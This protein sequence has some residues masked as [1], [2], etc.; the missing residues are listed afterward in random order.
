MNLITPQHLL[1]TY[2]SVNGDIKKFEKEIPYVLIPDAIRKY[3]IPRQYTHFEEDS[4]GD[5]SW[6]KF[7][8]NIRQI[9]KK[10]VDEI[11]GTFTAKPNKCA[12]GGKTH[13]EVFEKTNRY[14]NSDYFYGVKKHLVQ[15]FIFDEFIR[16]IID[17]SRKR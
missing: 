17:T 15:D 4:K 3:S 5:I 10:K 13:V 2:F 14:L 9:T 12:L 7:P 11:R 6:F 8:K 1:I 16:R